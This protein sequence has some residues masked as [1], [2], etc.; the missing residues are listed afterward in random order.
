MMEA[1]PKLKELYTRK[2]KP[3]YVSTMK[4]RNN[5]VP[6]V[7]PLFSPKAQEH[8][9]KTVPINHDRQAAIL[10]PLLEYQGEPSLLFT[11]RS[12]SLPTHASEVSFPGGHFDNNVDNSLEDTAIR[13]AQEE[14]LGDYD[15]EQ[16]Q[17]IGRASPL[18]S[19]NGTPV[20]PILAVL[21]QPVISSIN[22]F[23][24][25]VDEVDEVFVVSLS[26]LLEV[27][28][29]ED[30][31]RFRT[32]IPVFPLDHHK[33]WGLTAVVTRPILHQLLKPAFCL[34]S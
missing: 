9:W 12:S 29:V 20:V 26:K 22:T 32:K 27:E 21:T 17:L 14:L 1:L 5:D 2:A 24:G 31:Q 13:E 4:E 25:N 19:I 30:S 15:W 3:F 10:V 8:V 11:K 33:I 7:F 34:S 23:P 18:P 6:V 28:T 16:I